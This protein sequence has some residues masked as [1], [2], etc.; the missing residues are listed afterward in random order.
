MGSLA[1]SQTHIAYELIDENDPKVVVI[2]FLGRDLAGPGQAQA[3]R[4]QLESL[5]RPDLPRNY[6]IDFAKVQS[7]GST[8]FG[9]IVAFVRR[10]GRVRVCN[11]QPTLRLGASLIGLDDW[12]EF[13]VSRK[14]AI[15]AARRSGENTGASP[16]FVS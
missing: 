13:A 14:A 10:V 4:G 9:A 16:D 15:G 6:V 5:I 2:A 8:A 12:A 7:L 11:M 3:L 1:S